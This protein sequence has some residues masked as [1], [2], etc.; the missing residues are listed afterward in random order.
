TFC[1]A[2]TFGAP[3]TIGRTWLPTFTVVLFKWSEPSSGS[4]VSTSPTTRCSK[5][6]PSFWIVSTSS[7]PKVNFSPNSS[8]V[9]F[10]KSTYSFNQLKETNIR[11]LLLSHE[12]D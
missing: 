1:P 3:Q 11:L 4:H 12:T 2:A 6:S 8:G 9:I 7:P 10:D 5:P